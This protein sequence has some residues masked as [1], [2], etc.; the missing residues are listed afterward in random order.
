[1]V[2]LGYTSPPFP[3]KSL[4]LAVRG[5]LMEILPEQTDINIRLLDIKLDFKGYLY[6]HKLEE[7]DD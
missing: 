1:M 6:V 2:S 5:T 3:M 7:S 4:S